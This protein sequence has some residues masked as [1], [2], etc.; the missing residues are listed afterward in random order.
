M[1]GASWMGQSKPGGGNRPVALAYGWGMTSMQGLSGGALRGYI[2][3]S[4]GVTDKLLQQW[5]TNTVDI[6]SDGT[7]KRWIAMYAPPPVRMPVDH[8][9]KGQ[10]PT[11]TPDAL[12]YARVSLK[13]DPMARSA[14]PFTTL[15]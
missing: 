8:R 2:K 12:R 9:P 1:G 10:K 11:G 7:A 4:P 3:A 14:I 15:E 5:I 13:I 6:R